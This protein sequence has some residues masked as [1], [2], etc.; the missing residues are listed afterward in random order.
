MTR[1]F[2]HPD[3]SIT[4]LVLNRLQQEGIDAVIRGLAVGRG[5]GEIPPIAAWSEVWVAGDPT[6][7]AVRAVVA[8]VTSAPP[9][10]ADWTC[11][12]GET[13][14]GQFATCWAC[15]AEAPMVPS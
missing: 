1:V 15:G 13:M 9:P 4:H 8:E 5:M 7:E 10:D 6:A 12:C 14:E 11:A 2:S 3:P